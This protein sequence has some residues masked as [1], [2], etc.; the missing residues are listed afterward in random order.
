MLSE[1]L[2]LMA[3]RMEEHAH[4]GLTAEPEIVARIA[5]NL[6]DM[7]EEAQHLERNTRPVAGLGGSMRIAVPEGGVGPGAGA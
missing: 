4:T 6:R 2:A 1:K 7:M 5:S 3:S